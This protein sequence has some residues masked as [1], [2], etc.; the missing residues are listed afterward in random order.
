M[1]ATLTMHTGVVIVAF[2]HRDRHTR[3][4][5]PSTSDACFEVCLLNHHCISPGT[6]SA[7]SAAAA[8]SA[9][10][11]LYNSSKNTTSGLQPASLQ[12]SSYASVLLSHAVSLHDFA[13]NSP[14][15]RVLTQI[16]VPAVKDAYSSSGWEDDFVLSTLFLAWAS[17]STTQYQQA[18]SDYGLFKLGGKDDVFNWD[19]R[20]PALAVL[21]SQILHV[22]PSLAS[23]AKK[24]MSDWQS[25]AE[26]YFDRI[27]N[28]YGR[29]QLTGGECL[30]YQIFA[31]HAYL[32]LRWPV[33]LPWG[34]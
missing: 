7:A 17:N 16:S 1:K 21:F 23:T 24:A 31:V 25:E 11:L 6:D 13:A 19:D 15:G 32:T 30:E 18:E 34:L 9:C 29:G 10:S 27:L 14:N 4:M 20:T 2:Q 22:A 8:F 28:G 26:S 12:N 3:S 33:V 5:T